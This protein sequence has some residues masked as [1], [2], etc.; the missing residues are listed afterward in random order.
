MQHCSI[1]AL[2]HCS[3]AALQYCSIVAVLTALQHLSIAALQH[4][5]SSHF[6]DMQSAFLLLAKLSFPWHYQTM[7]HSPPTRLLVLPTM[8]FCFASQSLFP[9]ALETLHQ[10]STYHHL[11]SVVDVTMYADAHH[12][13]LLPTRARRT[14]HIHLRIASQPTHLA[15]QPPHP[16]PHHCI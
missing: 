13:M 4:T 7:S 14:G 16:L 2:Q 9:P 15:A 10:P 3:N 1:A 12:P 5:C 8:A 6:Q 11:H